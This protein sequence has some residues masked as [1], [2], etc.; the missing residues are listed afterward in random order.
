MRFEGSLLF[1]IAGLV[2]VMAAWRLS[3]DWSRPRVRFHARAFAL[4]V[5]LG[6][7]F[8]ASKDGLAIFP[9]TQLLVQSLTLDQNA[10][11]DAIFGACFWAV[12][13]MTALL[14]LSLWKPRLAAP[15]SASTDTLAR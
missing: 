3:R 5:G 1:W 6:V 12:N 15:L 7:A 13:W 8:T 9:S 2:L 11:L 14:V 4:S 10:S